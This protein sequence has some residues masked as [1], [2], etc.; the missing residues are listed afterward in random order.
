MLD[1]G[2][3]ALVTVDG[4]DM[5]C[6]MCSDKRFYSHKFNGNGVRYEVGVCIATGDIVW[7]SRPFR[8]GVNDLTVSREGGLLK[9]ARPQPSPSGLSRQDL[10]PRRPG[11]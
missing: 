4:A 8:C 3:Q 5:P 11:A 2:N 7:I 1:T 10:P 6:E 9:G